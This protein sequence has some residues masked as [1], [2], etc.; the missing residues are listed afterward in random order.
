MHIFESDTVISDC[1]NQENYEI[2]K[3]LIQTFQVYFT[4]L[5]VYSGDNNKKKALKMEKKL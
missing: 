1:H 5:D 2:F 3:E 4:S